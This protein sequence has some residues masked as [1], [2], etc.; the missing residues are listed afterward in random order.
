M[1]YLRSRGLM[2]TRSVALE[3]AEFGTRVRAMEKIIYEVIGVS[4]F[5]EF[6]RRIS[7]KS[8]E[9]KRRAHTAD[10]APVISNP[11]IRKQM[12]EDVPDA[13]SLRAG[14]DQIDERSDGVHLSYVMMASAPYGSPKAIAQD[15]NEKLKAPLEA[16]AN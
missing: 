13:G 12:V 4:G 10:S 6:I 8:C 15:L 2:L 1:V 5:V 3:A 16:A 11:L 9:G 7:T 14:D